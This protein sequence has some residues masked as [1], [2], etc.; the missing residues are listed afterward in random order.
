[1]QLAK[2]KDEL[3][4]TGINLINEAVDGDEDDDSFLSDGEKEELKKEAVSN[5]RRGL[6]APADA[7]GH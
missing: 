2:Q 7:Y 3:G 4:D 1:M 5:V 6:R